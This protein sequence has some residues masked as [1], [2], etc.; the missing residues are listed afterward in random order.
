MATII[1]QTTIWQQLERE[2]PPGLVELRDFLCVLSEFDSPLVRELRRERGNGCD[3]HPV[4]AMWNLL[5]I[6]LYLRRGKFSELLAELRRNSD[7]ARLL[8]FKELGP[9]QYD[10]PSKSAV[11][12]FHIKLQSREYTALVQD[13]FDRIT[14]AIA[15]ENPE[16]GEHTA[17]DAS[18]VRTHARPGPAKRSGEEKAPSND[19]VKG[20]DKAAGDDS[21]SDAPKLSSDPEASWSVKTKK[22]KGT[23]GK[24][25]KEVKKTFGYKLFAMTD[26]AAPVIWSVDVETGSQSDSSMAMPLLDAA[27]EILGGER[28]KTLAMDKG[29]DSEEN[30]RE[31]FRR[32]VAAIVPVRDVPENLDSLP[33]EDRE[34]PISPGG[35]LYYDRYSG[36]VVCYDASSP[37]EPV[38]REMSYAGFESDRETHKFRCPL[39]SACQSCGSFE[40]CAA[41][42]SGSLGRQVRVP[43]GLD[44]RR[45]APVYPRSKRWKRL[46]NGR[47][48]VERVNAYLKDVLPL[49]RHAL[50][51][52]AAIKLRVLL[53]SMTLN[54]RTLMI[55]RA[56][57]AQRVAA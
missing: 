44:S 6:A 52:Q 49:E 1:R 39:G 3:D 26:S 7:M 31:A 34:A 17:L 19:E 32:G 23:D 29:F 24:T 51:G 8:G 42:S 13:V 18:D 54:L 30:V 45:F 53:A 57:A 55:L 43:M 27:Q 2:L 56:E 33:K 12:R 21:A 25:H 14:M 11:S 4:E 10:L 36:E 20:G 15:A 48:A 50:R 37:G 16:L 41:G 40:S 22:R 35:N 38:R 47:S 9:N 5:A 28:V 46:Y